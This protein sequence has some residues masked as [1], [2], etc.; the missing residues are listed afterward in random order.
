MNAAVKRLRHLGVDL[1]AKTSQ[2]TKRRLDMAAWAAEP[3]VEIEVT[4]GGVEIVEPHQSHDPATEPDAFRV[5]GRPVDGLCRL[6]E[7]IGLAL[8]FLGSICRCRCIRGSGLGGLV[9]RATALGNGALDADGTETN[10]E[11]EAGNGEVAQN[12]TF[13]PKHTS[14]HKFPDLLSTGLIRPVLM[15]FK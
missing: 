15:P 3:V 4:K 9:L 10:Q 2:A 6:D 1:A 8:I 12:R 14:T 5:S 11:G 7:F 13:Q